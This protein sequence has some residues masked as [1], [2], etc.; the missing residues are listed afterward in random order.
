[1]PTRRR[2]QE[3][4]PQ[5]RTW[6]S[7]VYRHPDRS[8]A[9]RKEREKHLRAFVRALA[10]NR[11]TPQP[12]NLKPKHVRTAIRHWK[13]SGASRDTVKNRLSTIRWLAGTLGKPNVVERTNAAYDLPDPDRQPRNPAEPLYFADR[14]HTLS[15]IRDPYV[16]ASVGLQEAFGLRRKEAI[17]IRP[18]EADHGDALALQR[19]W[20]KGGRPRQIPILNDR[21]RAALDFAK[22]VAGPGRAL[23]PDGKTYAAQRRTYHHQTANAG[24]S[25]LHGL[26]HAYAC[27]RYQDL[28]GRLA[29]RQGGPAGG[30]LAP[31]ERRQDRRARLQIAQELGHGRIRITYG[32]CGQ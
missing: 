5:A 12:R 16:R 28:T 17:M 1:M 4:S 3:S 27:R 18:H 26:R 14:E 8:Y 30:D 15:R 2:P 6:V 23:I 22:A 24:L 25:H 10:A 13:A 21:Q 32:Y 9:T 7:Y 20:T 31:D 19:T 11:M 29:P